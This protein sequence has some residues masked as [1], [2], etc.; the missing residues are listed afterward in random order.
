MRYSSSNRPFRAIVADDHPIYCEGLA[1]LLTEVSADASISKAVTFAAVMDAAMVE[2]AP[3]LFLLD[4]NFPGMVLPGSINLIREKFVNASIIIVSMSDDHTTADRVMA[5]GADGF[6]SKAASP[7]VMRE[8]IEA[9]LA[10]E[11]VNVRGQVGLSQISKIEVDFPGLTARQIDVLKLLSQGKANKEI[12]KE[13]K[14]SP[15]TVR[16]HVSGILNQLDVVSRAGAAAIAGRY[17][18]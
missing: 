17:T 15:F 18:F 6:I 7:D 9:V 2:G 12:A 5:S 4:L 10:G 1:S 8:A 13:L 14:I 3:D 11:F 16:I